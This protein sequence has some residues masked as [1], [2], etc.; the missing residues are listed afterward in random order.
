MQLA[1]LDDNLPQ[2][3]GDGQRD[4]WSRGS[5]DNAIT[6]H[7]RD[8]VAFLYRETNTKNVRHYGLHHPS[9]KYTLP[10]V[11]VLICLLRGRPVPEMPLPRC[12]RCDIP[13][14]RRERTWR[15]LSAAALCPLMACARGPPSAS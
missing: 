12:L 8:S 7:E 5:G 3:R 2:N 13:M 1:R 9:R 4:A 11:C 15:P 10:L 14:E 6:A